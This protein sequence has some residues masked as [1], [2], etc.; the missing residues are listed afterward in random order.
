M[1]RRG[2]K[3]WDGEREREKEGEGGHSSW[4]LFP[5]HYP[6]SLF[7]SAPFDESQTVH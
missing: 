1:L 4:L 5:C 2:G 3:G 7:Q 6:R